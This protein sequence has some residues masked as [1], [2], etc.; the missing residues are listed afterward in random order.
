LPRRKKSR[1]AEIKEDHDSESEHAAAPARSFWSGTISFGLVSIP[2]DLFGAVRARQK[3]LKMVDKE[4][5]A[6]GRQYQCSADGK[7]LSNNDLVRG[8]QTDNGEMVVISDDE[9]ESF[10][11][12]ESRDIEIRRFVPR[13][14]IPPVYFDRPYFL[15]PSGKSS[16]AY[17][18]LAKTMERTGKVAIGVFVM[19]AHE[20]LVA[21]L[22]E[23]GV[24]RAETLRH[25]NEVRSPDLVGLPHKSKAPAK[26]VSELERE[27]EHLSHDHL[28]LSELK[29]VDAD[30]LQKLVADKQE[31]DQDVIEQRELQDDDPEEEDGGN[32]IDFMEVLKRSLSKK[33]V[34][35]TAEVSSGE[36]KNA[37]AAST[38]KTPHGAKKRT[39]A[40]KPRAKHQHKAPAH[41]A[42]K[43]SSRTTKRHAAHTR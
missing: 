26:K 6:L 14:Q 19:R 10:A 17:N 25:A 22:S 2:V 15:A 5:H 37:A 12:E 30:A 29:D 33:A 42:A 31:K 23:N 41:R 13:E 1:A 35:R 20:Y 43:P 39:T 40:A 7:K 27:I 16:K 3:S 28:D 38:A 4:G 24:L 34:A 11:P 36:N 32:V 18:L 9:F 21:I 8:F